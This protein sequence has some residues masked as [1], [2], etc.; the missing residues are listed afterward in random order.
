MLK[1][2]VEEIKSTLGRFDF[3]KEVIVE[4]SSCC[5]LKC[6]M[7]PQQQLTRERKFMSND[8]F[9]KIVDEIKK[10][11]ETKRIW[12]AIMGEPLL[13]P[14]IIKKMSY[15]GSSELD[16]HFNTNALL[17]NEK[18][19]EN[20]IISGVKS[21]YIGLD[22]VNMSTYKKVRVGGSY[23]DAVKNTIKLLEMAKGSDVKVYAQ[24][25]DMDENEGERDDFIEFWKG[26]GA[27]VKIRPRLGWG[28]GVD[29]DRLVLQD[30]QRDFPCPWLNRTIS[31]HAD[32]NI[33]Q[34]DADWDDKNVIGNVNNKS[35]KEI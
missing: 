20:L 25:I 26:M 31:I 22:A 1:Q 2:R 17:M 33:V 21:F 11:S 27:I 19:A 35:I 5:N 14:E 16:I 12:P 34:C 13:D 30:S 28:L 6:V 24:F 18:V 10:E 8:I 29:T 7:C 9:F 4:V 3:P 23:H 15:A 32:G